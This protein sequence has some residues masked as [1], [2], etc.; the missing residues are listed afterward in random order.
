M[1]SPPGHPRPSSYARFTSII[2]LMPLPTNPKDFDL[3]K[4]AGLTDDIISACLMAQAG[5]RMLLAKMPL[6]IAAVQEAKQSHRR[7]FF[8]EGVAERQALD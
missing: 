1:W 7:D 2:L 8:P 5:K 4:V 6:M 3:G